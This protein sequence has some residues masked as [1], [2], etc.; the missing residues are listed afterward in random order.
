MINH[1][2]TEALAWVLCHLPGDRRLTGD[3]MY[4]YLLLCICK[5]KAKMSVVMVSGL[6]VAE[7]V[8]LFSKDALLLCEG[9]T[10]NPSGDVCCRKHHPSRWVCTEQLEQFT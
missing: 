4:L 6:R 2:L 1:T 5:V 9:F 8:L 10:L 3:L 7:G